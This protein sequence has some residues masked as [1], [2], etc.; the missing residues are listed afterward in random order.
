MDYDRLL[1]AF[2]FLKLVCAGADNVAFSQ[3]YRVTWGAEYVRVG[4]AEAVQISLDKASGDKTV[5][6]NMFLHVRVS[7]FDAWRNPHILSLCSCRN[8]VL[9]CMLILRYTI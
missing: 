3:D 2:I 4:K 5:L 9:Y 7:N 6:T 8:R 1:T